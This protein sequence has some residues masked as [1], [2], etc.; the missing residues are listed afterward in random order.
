MTNNTAV[1]GILEVVICFL[2]LFRPCPEN[3]WA[4]R[5]QNKNNAETERDITLAIFSLNLGIIICA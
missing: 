4:I 5:A 1:F 3:K 2:G